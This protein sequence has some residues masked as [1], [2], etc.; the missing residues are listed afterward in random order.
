M[1]SMV[2][3]IQS[4]RNVMQR[5][6]AGTTGCVELNDARSVVSHFKCVNMVQMGKAILHSINYEIFHEAR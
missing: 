5:K 2:R 1:L 6:V 4:V 3:K